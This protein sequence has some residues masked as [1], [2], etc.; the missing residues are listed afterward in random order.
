[1]IMDAGL[2]LNRKTEKSQLKGY[3][4]MGLI[5][6]PAPKTPDWV[7]MAN[8]KAVKKAEVLR[9]VEAQIAGCIDLSPEEMVDAA[10]IMVDRIEHKLNHDCVEEGPAGPPELQLR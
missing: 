6:R 1:M 3:R 9:L 2:H 10:F 8:Q 7:K 5:P 4:S